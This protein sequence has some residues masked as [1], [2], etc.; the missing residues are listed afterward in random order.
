MAHIAQ[1][2]RLAVTLLVE[3]RLGIGR[4][5]MSRSIASPC[6]SCAQHCVPDRPR[7]CRCHPSSGSS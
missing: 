1:L 5:R 4:A 6:G 2:S 7:L 3:P